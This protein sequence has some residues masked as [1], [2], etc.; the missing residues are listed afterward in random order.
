VGKVYENIIT[1][2]ILTA[3]L[4]AA[5]GVGIFVGKTRTRLKHVEDGLKYLRE[6][7]TESLSKNLR[8]FSTLND[9]NNKKELDG[10]IN[11]LVTRIDHMHEELRRQDATITSLNSYLLNNASNF[12]KALERGEKNVKSDTT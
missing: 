3:A 7:E 8:E 11:E 6:T 5:V 4:S 1:A 2:G 9:N 12:F 10:R